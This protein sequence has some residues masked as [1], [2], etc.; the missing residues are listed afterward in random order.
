MVG[1]YKISK[2]LTLAATWVYGTGN[3]ITMPQGYMASSAHQLSKIPYVWNPSFSTGNSQIDYTSRNNFRMEPY[4]RLDIGLRFSKEIKK[5]LQTWE[6][7][8][9]NAYSR[10]NPFFYYG[11][12]DNNNVVTLKKVT[13][14]PLIP[15]LS[16]SLKFK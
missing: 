9:Y 13:L 8:F 3:A 12:E 1:I 2:Y 14:F 15:S 16:W 7:S 6:L 10:M 5:G 11:S 4:H